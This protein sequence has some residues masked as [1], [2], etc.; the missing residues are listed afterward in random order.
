MWQGAAWQTALPAQAAKAKDELVSIP[1]ERT[2]RGELTLLALLIILV[3][4]IDL[5]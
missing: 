3:K 1:K 5:C 2:Q 4:T